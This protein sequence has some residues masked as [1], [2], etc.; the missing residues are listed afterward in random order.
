MTTTVENLSKGQTLVVGARKVKGGKFQVEF[1]EIVVNPDARPNLLSMF[2]A[3]D[4]RFSARTSKP[5]RAWM[6]VEANDFFKITG[7]DISGATEDGI[8]L[9]VLNPTANGERIHLEIRETVG[10]KDGS[11]EQSNSA[12]AAKQVTGADGSRR[13]FVKDNQLIFAKGTVVLGEPKH[14]ILLADKIAT[15]AELSAMGINLT[16]EGIVRQEV[17]LTADANPLA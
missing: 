1:A 3:S 9:N 17:I 11:Y 7:I 8:T 2:N 6:T 10:A 14:Q 16:G 13:Y 15:V 4:D 12:R 5:R